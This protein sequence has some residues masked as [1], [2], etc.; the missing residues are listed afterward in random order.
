MISNEERTSLQA[1]WVHHF[2]RQLNR[3]LNRQYQVLAS[4]THNRSNYRLDRAI[5]G[6]RAS[7]LGGPSDLGE[8]WTALILLPLSQFDPPSNPPLSFSWSNPAK[9]Q[10]LSFNLINNSKE[11]RVHHAMTSTL[12][13]FIVWSHTTQT[14]VF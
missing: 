9:T 14:W 11:S 7:G 8:W 3:H 12:S 10:L 1:S 2:L 5:I 13:M 4:V 6:W